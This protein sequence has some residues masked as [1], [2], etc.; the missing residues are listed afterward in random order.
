VSYN[1]L[2]QLMKDVRRD[3]L[4]DVSEGKR[5]PEWVVNWLEPSFTARPVKLIHI[6]VC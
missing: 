3:G 1:A 4:K 2:K 6:I 5:L